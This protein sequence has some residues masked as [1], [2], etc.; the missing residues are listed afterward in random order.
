VSSDPALDAIPCT[1]VAANLDGKPANDRP[2]Q[3]K[4]AGAYTHPFAALDL[5]AGVVGRATSKTTFSKARTMTV[6][7]PDG[8]AS[9]QT[10]TYFYDG[11]GSE[12]VD[13][14][15]FDLDFAVEGA[16]RSFDRAQ[17][18]FKFDVF[19]LL[20]SQEKLDVNN[21]AWC[22][23]TATAACQ[24]A[25]SNFGTATSRGSFNGPRTIRFTFLVRY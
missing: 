4:F 14:T 6:L 9:G 11:R 21:T 3:L 17:L 10:Q 5:T 15:D 22:N 23:S 1:E 16:V 20:D 8:S 24:T 7:L 13:G 12:R 19:N 25:V 18:G 2:H